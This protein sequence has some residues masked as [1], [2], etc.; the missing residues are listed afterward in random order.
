MIAFGQELNNVKTQPSKGFSIGLNAG[1]DMPLFTNDYRLYGLKGSPKFGL[2]LDYFFSKFGIGLDYDFIKNK[3][4]S[5]LNDNIYFDT[6]L[7]QNSQLNNVSK[8]IVRHFIGIGPNYN[9]HLLRNKLNVKLYT[10]VGLSLIKG[11]DLISSALNPNT[12]I[13]E[14]H[15]V[16][17]GY[18]QM[19]L[20]IKS[21]FDIHYALSKN[22]SVGIGTYFIYQHRPTPD[23]SID[24]NN[25]GNKGLVYGESPFFIKN[26]QY[27]L[28][29]TDAKTI[30]EASCSIYNSVGLDFGIKYTFGNRSNRGPCSTCG[31]PNDGHKVVVTVRDDI[32]KQVIPQA[33]VALNNIDG[34]IIATG[35]TNSFGVVDFGLIPHGN[36][37]AIANVFGAMTNTVPILDEEFTPGAIIQKEVLYSDLRFI[38]KGV[39]INKKNRVPEPN[40]VVSLTDSNTKQVKQVTSS[41]K[42]EFSFLLDKSSTYEI[43]G[44]K[45]NRLS[46]FAQASTVGLTR[47]T[48]LFVELQLGVDNFDCD[49]G[50]VLDIK[51]EYD[52]D[53]LLSESKFELDRLVRYM[54]DHGLSKVEL[55]SHTDARGSNEYNQD[56]SQRRAQSAVNYITSRGIDIARIAAFGYGETRILNRCKDGVNC[57]DAEHRINRRTEAK[58]LCN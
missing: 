42:G 8:G 25:I 16:F 44:I 10:R 50:T 15:L 12:K 47:S 39:V 56:L 34:Q 20:A 45:E 7:T 17:T 46:D 19:T 32:T 3:P 54:N 37:T 21:G 48:T 4:Y 41:G 18:D 31:C 5:K 24:I 22:L 29:N 14:Y 1:Y 26:S 11:G 27:V 55:S 36:Y 35:T 38:L 33:D 51:Y 30:K 40:V 58:L 2:K 53:A 28:E 6:L 43:V 49:Q 9:I 57:S 52:K 23:L 13:D